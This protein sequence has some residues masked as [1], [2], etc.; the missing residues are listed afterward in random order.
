[1]TRHHSCPVPS[2]TQYS[3]PCAARVDCG[4]TSTTTANHQAVLG[5]PS[6]PQSA[7]ENSKGYSG[8]TIAGILTWGAVRTLTSRSIVV[9]H[10]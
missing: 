2:L 5:H 9:W 8:A 4:G 10:N 3:S 6:H 1:M 7:L